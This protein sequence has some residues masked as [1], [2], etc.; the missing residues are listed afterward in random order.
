MKKNALIVGAR[1]Q[2][3]KTAPLIAEL[4]RNYVTIL[5]HTGQHFDF[6]MSEKFFEELD[7]PDP[8]YH[9]N[10]PSGST[11][12]QTGRIIAGL[13]SVLEFEKPDFT[14]VVGDTNSTLAGAVASAKQGIPLVHVEA[15]VRSKNKNIPEQINRVM[16]DSV[17]DCFLCPSPSSVEN[18]AKEGKTD[19]VYDTGDI[20]YDCLRGFEKKIPEIPELAIDIPSEFALATLHRADAVDN[21]ENL[22][23]ILKSLASSPI[24]VIFPIHPRTRKMI[25][26]FGLTGDIPEH[27]KVIDPIGYLSLLSCLR[28]CEFVITDSGGVQREA[29]YLGKRVILPRDETEWIELQESGWVHVAGYNFRVTEILEKSP[30]PYPKFLFRPAAAEMIDRVRSN[31]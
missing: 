17:S 12:R 14:I 21:S 18:L 26:R 28:A 20:I 1:P 13:E 4:M 8:D 16:T 3:I 19:G 22:K 25:D 23:V 15:G 27:V 24:P 7:L 10:T 9:L 29:V 5:I 6:S 2:F 31:F 30:G 11:G